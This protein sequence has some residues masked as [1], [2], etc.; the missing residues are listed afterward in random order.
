M[1]NC[2]MN[3][4]SQLYMTGLCHLVIVSNVQMLKE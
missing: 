4:E 3:A 1:D 2:Y